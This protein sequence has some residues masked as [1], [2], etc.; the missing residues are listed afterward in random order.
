MSFKS[1]WRKSV[2]PCI[3]GPLGSTQ[4]SRSWMLS[5]VRWRL[6]IAASGRSWMQSALEVDI[7]AA[8]C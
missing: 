6:A 3:I 5:A 8:S 4:S 1:N 2:L 7:D